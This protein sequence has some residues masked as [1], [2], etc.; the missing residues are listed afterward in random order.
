MQP[1]EKKVLAIK[2]APAPKTMEP[3]LGIINYYRKFMP[4]L[5]TLVASLNQLRQKNIETVP[6]LYS[7]WSKY[8]DCL[9][10]V[11]QNYE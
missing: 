8:W 2:Q 6:P 4:N 11:K 9:I 3:F 7:Y 10:W 1:L 5:S